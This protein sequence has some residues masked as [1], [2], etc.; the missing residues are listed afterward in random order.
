MQRCDLCKRGCLGTLPLFKGL[1]PAD[2]QDIQQLVTHRTYERGEIAIHEGD[3]LFGLH[4][5][6]AG[7]AK[8][9]TQNTNGNEHVLRLLQAGDFYG[10]LSLVAPMNAPSTMQALTPLKLC[11][12]NGGELRQ[13]L[14]EHPVATLSIL[15]ALATRLSQSE[16]FS[17]ELGLLDSRQRVAALLL[18]LAKRQGRQTLNGIKLQLELNRT[19]LANMIGL[20]QET[21][22]RCL[23]E[24]RR[25]GWIATEGHRNIYL[26]D[27]EALHKLRLR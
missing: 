24:F 20:R 18:Q 9:F 2:I 21:F 14:L 3:Q 7:Q 15:E 25:D 1:Q 6:E 16:Q 5:V 12:V 17:L 4:I 27:L 13:Y 26:T 8:V 23:S 11:S 22:S 10:E 19:E